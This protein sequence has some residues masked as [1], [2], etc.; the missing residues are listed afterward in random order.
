MMQASSCSQG[1]I[2]A[3]AR[4]IT[5]S[6][7]KKTISSRICFGEQVASTYYYSANSYEGAMAFQSQNDST[8]SALIFLRDNG[9]QYTHFLIILFNTYCRTQKELHVL[10]TQ[11][12]RFLLLIQFT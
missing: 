5:Y 2:S 12:C 9:G 4:S 6:G 3:T 11:K 8:Q 1:N 7:H 10:S